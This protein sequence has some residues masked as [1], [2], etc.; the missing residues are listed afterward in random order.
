MS[1]QWVNN[2]EQQSSFDWSGKNTGHHHICSKNHGFWLR[3]SLQAV[4]TDETSAYY[5][6]GPPNIIIKLVKA[7]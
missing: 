7:H 2:G 3:F 4:Q 5:N 6:M 1:I